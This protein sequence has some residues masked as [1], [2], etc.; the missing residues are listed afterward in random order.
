V[1]ISHRGREHHDVAGGLKVPQDEFSHGKAEYPAADMA[2]A[3]NS[4]TGRA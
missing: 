2:Q 1:E 3:V 4:F